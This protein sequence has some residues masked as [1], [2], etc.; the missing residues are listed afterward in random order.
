MCY[1]YN[2]SNYIHLSFSVLVPGRN[3]QINKLLAVQE[4][5]MLLYILLANETADLGSPENIDNIIQ[6]ISEKKIYFNRAANL[7]PGIQ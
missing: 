2:K 5:T 6:S 4:R 7:R 1:S 3:E